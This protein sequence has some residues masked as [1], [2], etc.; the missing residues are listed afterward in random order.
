V[1]KR[2]TIYKTLILALDFPNIIT[3]L[4]KA[5]QIFCAT[6]ECDSDSKKQCFLPK[7][8]VT[9]ICDTNKNMTHMG[10]IIKGVYC[11][12]DSGWTLEP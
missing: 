2:I 6:N 5:L 9:K 12:W 10:T 1:P 8:I 3:F 11:I 4:K 7:W